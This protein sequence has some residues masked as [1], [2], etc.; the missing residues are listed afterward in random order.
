MVNYQRRYDI[1]EQA[2]YLAQF[3]L[4]LD[5]TNNDIKLAISNYEKLKLYI[6]P[7]EIQRLFLLS[8]NKNTSNMSDNILLL[9][10]VCLNLKNIELLQN[11]TP[12]IYNIIKSIH[13]NNISGY[14]LSCVFNESDKLFFSRFLSSTIIN[15]L[16]TIFRHDFSERM[17][18]NLC[19]N[20]LNN[21]I[22]GSYINI[23][24]NTSITFNLKELTKEFDYFITLLFDDNIKTL[25]EVV[26]ESI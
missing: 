15:K 23:I 24:D 21:I 9:F 22:T 26:E 13:V 18:E 14:K 4:L 7:N 8:I 17:S 11:N 16:N 1:Y 12:I 25:I 19:N 5:S 3:K 10:D 20:I 6:L 2:L